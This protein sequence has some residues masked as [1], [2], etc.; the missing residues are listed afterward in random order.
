MAQQQPAA[1]CTFVYYGAYAV[2]RLRPASGPVSGGTAVRLLGAGFVPTGELAVCLRLCGVERRVP[3]AFVS[4]SEIRFLTPSF[5]DAGDA[6]VALSL[7][8][9]EYDPASAEQVF[10]YTAPA[11]MLPCTVQ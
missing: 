10:R 2:H 7:N 9:H 6:R 8:G 11:S 1:A 5:A 4:D 3:A